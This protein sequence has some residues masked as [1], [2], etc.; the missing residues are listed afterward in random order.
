M[1]TLKVSFYRSD[2]WRDA[3]FVA[4]GCRPATIGQETFDLVEATV[5]QRRNVAALRIADTQISISPGVEFDAVPTLAE[6]LDAYQRQEKQRAEKEADAEAKRAAD[7]VRFLEEQAQRKA[8][9]AVVEAAKQ[10]R[11]VEKLAWCQAHGSDRLR[12]GVERGHDCQALYVRERAAVEAPGF[13]ADIYDAAKWKS[14]T[15]PSAK[16][17]DTA[18][19]AEALGLGPVDV[20]WLTAPAADTKTDADMDYADGYGWSACEA[21]VISGYLGKYDLVQ[22]L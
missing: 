8:A 9:E 5:E 10:Q 22:A 13:T 15:C 21:V 20:V 14:A 11:Q 16:S 7:H 2:K 6:A 12:R 1:S 19:A 4:T 18:E 17:L 3:E